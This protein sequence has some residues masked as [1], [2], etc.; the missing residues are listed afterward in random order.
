MVNKRSVRGIIFALCSGCCWA[1]SGTVG[2]FLFTQKNADPTWVTVVRMTTAGI[3]FLLMAAANRRSREELKNLLSN[4][5]DMLYMIVF[6][7]AGL[8]M[9]QYA[10]L[11]S[12]EHTNAGVA[13]AIQYSGEA[14]VLVVTCL[15]FRRLPFKSEFLG[16]LIMLCAVFL[17]STHG[18]IGH[19][20]F[21]YTTIIWLIV[22]AVALMLY[23]VLPPRVISKYGNTPVMGVGLLIGSAVLA[24]ITRVWTIDPGIID[25]GTIIGLALMIGI[26]TV[27]AFSMFMQSTVL[28]GPIK[29]GMLSAVET[30]ASPVISSIWLGMNFDITDYI[31]FIMMFAMVIMLSLPELMG[32]SAKASETASATARTARTARHVSPAAGRAAHNLNLGK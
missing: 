2:Q 4:G 19:T 10:Y 16:L 20:E 28:I 31:G 23:T 25:G 22:A 15:K 14:L 26:G 29:A 27:L 21:S 18:R 3:V 5:R 13:T 24:L 32:N 9:V 7:I 30:V 12:I 11:V 1:F 17:I 8:L 6:S